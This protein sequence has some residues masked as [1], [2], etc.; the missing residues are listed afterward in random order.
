MHPRQK[1]LAVVL[2]FGT[3]G[4]FASGAAE[5]ACH[6]ASGRRDAFERHVASVCVE[7]ATQASRGEGKEVRP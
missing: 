2:A 5:L 7:A 3:V 1:F 4:G 6:R